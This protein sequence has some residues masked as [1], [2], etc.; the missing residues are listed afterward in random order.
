MGLLNLFKP[1]ETTAFAQSL[2]RDIAK[3]YPPNLDQQP[4][5]RPSINRLTRILEEACERAVDFK[6]KNRLGVIGKARLSNTFRWEL[7]GLGYTKEFSS[8]AVEALVVSMS[9]KPKQ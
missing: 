1:S 9:R 7:D 5:K 3:R 4:G 2:A 8:L 6:I